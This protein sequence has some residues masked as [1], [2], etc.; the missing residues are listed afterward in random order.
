M[1]W[2]SI[3]LGPVAELVIK[4]IIALALSQIQQWTPGFERTQYS[5]TQKHIVNTKLDTYICFHSL[6]FKLSYLR[7]LEYTCQTWLISIFW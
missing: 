6:Y 2:V 7:T 1:I 5:L 4:L 3:H